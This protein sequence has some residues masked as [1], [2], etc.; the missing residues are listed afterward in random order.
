M[1]TETEL[2]NLIKESVKTIIKEGVDYK[3]ES[4]DMLENL[5]NCL[6]ADQLCDRLA[7]RLAGQIDYRGLYETLQEI[8]QMECNNSD[9]LY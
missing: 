9:D 5:K 8:Y 7:N 3:T 6:G 2:K 4:F 1:L